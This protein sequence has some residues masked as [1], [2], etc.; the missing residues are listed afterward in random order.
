VARRVLI[1]EDDDSARACYG[2]LLARHGYEPA[3]ESDGM[4]VER[5]LDRYRD[6]DLVILDY[7]MPGLDGLQLLARLRR[8][9]FRAPVL[10]VTAS[11]IEEIQGEARRLGVRQILAKPLNIPGFLRVIEELTSTAVP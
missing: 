1:I 7:R 4:S 8:L 3:L 5:N 2:R 11:A 9:R 10:L 6:V